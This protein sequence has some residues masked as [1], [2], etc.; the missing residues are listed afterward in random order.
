MN[1]ESWYEPSREN[2]RKGKKSEIKFVTCISATDF[3]SFWG[4]RLDHQDKDKDKLRGDVLDQ[5]VTGNG[6]ISSRGGWVLY[7]GFIFWQCRK[8]WTNNYFHLKKEYISKCKIEL[9]Y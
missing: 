4:L 2:A 1:V 3:F 5:V 6:K 7:C 9:T 8:K